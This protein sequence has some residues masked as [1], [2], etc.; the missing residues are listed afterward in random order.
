[1][2]VCELNWMSGVSGQ[3]SLRWHLRPS[4][5]QV[6]TCGDRIMNFESQPPPEPNFRWCCC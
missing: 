5:S 3:Q 4:D 2:K 1:M 6:W